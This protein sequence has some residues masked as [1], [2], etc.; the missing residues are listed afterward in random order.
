MFAHRP[1]NKLCTTFV[2]LAYFK[3]LLNSNEELLEMHVR[4]VILVEMM[5]IVVDINFIDHDRQTRSRDILTSLVSHEAQSE[6]L[7]QLCNRMFFY[8]GRPPLGE[9][10]GSAQYHTA[11]IW[12]SN[13]R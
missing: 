3:I 11:I 4:S 8:R 5:G 10:G 2:P 9:T 13:R 1:E 6:L 12:C 7:D